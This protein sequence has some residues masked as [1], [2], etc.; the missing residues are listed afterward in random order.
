MTRRMT[1]GWPA[2]SKTEYQQLQRHLSPGVLTDETE[3]HDKRHDGPLDHV[4]VLHDSLGNDLLPLGALAWRDT[5]LELDAE[6]A[7]ARR[8]NSV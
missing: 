8:G 5:I 6:L 4:P 1:K 7:R 3:D 2:P